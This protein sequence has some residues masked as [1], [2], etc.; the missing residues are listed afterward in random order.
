MHVKMKI[1][2]KI[3]IILKEVYSSGISWD[4]DKK[5]NIVKIDELSMISYNTIKAIGGSS[6]LKVTI[7]G[8]KKGKVVY[9]LARHWEDKPEMVK[10][11]MVE[12]I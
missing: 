12:V 8:K 2:E 11:L 5:Q 1:D 9:N 10:Q 3:T 4:F 6:E 7:I